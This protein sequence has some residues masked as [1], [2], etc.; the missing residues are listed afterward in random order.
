MKK[1]IISI[2]LVTLLTAGT[3][4]TGC[5]AGGLGNIV[6]EEKDFADFTYV[7]VEGTFDIKID[8]SDSFSTTISADSNLF[9][10]ITVTKEGQTLRIY[11]NPRH[12]F[13]DFTLPV[14]SLKAVITMPE[15]QGIS[16]SGACKGTVTGFKSSRDFDLNVSGASSLS[17]KDM[18]A[19][20][21]AF[22]VSGASKVSGTMNCKDAGFEV[23]GASKVELDGSA[24]NAILT[25]SGASKAN[26]VDFELDDANVKLSGAS[27]ATVHA[28]GRL[29]A[30]L[31]AASSL[32]FLG[33]PTMGNIHVSGASTLKHK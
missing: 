12:T 15:L 28:K 31:S 9:D 33:N 14:R 24:D 17:I 2:T 22:E 1:A 16:L 27:E 3:L 21:A 30:V 4:F 8:Q 13:T 11:L 20:D 10:Y 7:S 5:T 32:Y 19:G 29:D 6:T 25:I 23:S 18:E 26:M